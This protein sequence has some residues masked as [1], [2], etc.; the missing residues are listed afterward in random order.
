LIRHISIQWITSNSMMW[1]LWGRC[2]CV[3][4]QIPSSPSNRF[5]YK[6]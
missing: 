3:T 5:F 2:S 6:K 1:I 4:H